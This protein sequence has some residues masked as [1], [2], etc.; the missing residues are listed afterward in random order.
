MKP[1][2]LDLGVNLL[3]MWK[4][5]YVEPYYEVNEAKM[6]LHGITVGLEN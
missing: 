1:L 2:F 5:S 6:E 3:L 4:T